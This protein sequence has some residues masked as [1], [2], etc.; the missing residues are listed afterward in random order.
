[1]QRAGHL[2][3][4]GIM[5]SNLADLIIVQSTYVTYYFYQ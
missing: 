1:M 2:P 4:D 5:S 3:A